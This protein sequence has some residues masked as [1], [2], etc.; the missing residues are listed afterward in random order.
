M[1]D[2]FYFCKDCLSIYIKKDDKGDYCADC[3]SR[4]I[5]EGHN[6]DYWLHRFIKRHKLHED[7][8]PYYFSSRK[9]IL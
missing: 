5:N 9:H 4:R 2:I 3:G 6:M 1:E 7:E 8:N